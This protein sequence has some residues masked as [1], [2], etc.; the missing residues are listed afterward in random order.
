MFGGMFNGPGSSNM[1][2][3][4]MIAFLYAISGIFSGIYCIYKGHIEWSTIASA[5]GIPALV[6]IVLLFFTTWGDLTKTVAAVRG[7]NVT[8]NSEKTESNPESTEVQVQVTHGKKEEPKIE[9][10]GKPDVL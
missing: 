8:V 9:N 4:R 6:C 2:S 7:S 5:F 3:R 1:S 10:I